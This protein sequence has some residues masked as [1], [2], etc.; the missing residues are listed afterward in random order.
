MQAGAVLFF[1][2]VDR[3]YPASQIANLG[4][5]LLDGLQPF[6]PLA[7]S[8]LRLGSVRSPLAV[9][10]VQLLNVSNLRAETRDLFP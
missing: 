8:H 4:K 5:L 3:L 6:L 10:L 2:L 7:V 9:L 1:D